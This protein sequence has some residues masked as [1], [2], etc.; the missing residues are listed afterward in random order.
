MNLINDEE[1]SCLCS[2]L[3]NSINLKHFL[4]H[5]FGN[6][7]SLKGALLLS[8]TLAKLPHL[9]TLKLYLYN[10][11]PLVLNKVSQ[12]QNLKNKILKY[13]RLVNKIVSFDLN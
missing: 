8:D 2:Y 1:L 4:L 9:F 10:N 7:I 12:Q 13:K 11:F 3:Q 6:A 5:F